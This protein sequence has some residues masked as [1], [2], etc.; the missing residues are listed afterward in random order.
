MDQAL[1]VAAPVAVVVEEGLDVDAGGA[2][3]LR[4]GSNRVYRPRRDTV[5]YE[6]GRLTQPGSGAVSFT[7]SADWVPVAVQAPPGLTGSGDVV[8]IGTW[9]VLPDAGH[10]N[11]DN[12]V[13]LGR[14]LDWLSGR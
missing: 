7:A 9:R 1:E 2:E 10:P 3:V 5:R 6:G 14:L 11:P 8:A 13:F 4:V 12:L